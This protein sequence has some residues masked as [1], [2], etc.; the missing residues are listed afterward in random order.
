MVFSWSSWSVKSATFSCNSINLPSVERITRGLA[1]RPIRVS[2]RLLPRARSMSRAGEHG[3]RLRCGAV[4]AGWMLAAG[5]FTMAHAQYPGR[6]D[7]NKGA[8]ATPVLRAT[9]VLEY[10]GDLDKPTAARLIPVAVW[11]GERYQPGGLYMAQPMPLAV[12][13]GTAYELLDAGTSKGLFDVKAAANVSGSWVATGT[14]QRPAP[15]K[16]ARLKPS[17]TLP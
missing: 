5:F 1:P 4:F 6:V 15:V 12:E 3:L 17:K 10:T 7:P 8:G 13:S 14:Y 9:A 11:D 2:Y 16:V